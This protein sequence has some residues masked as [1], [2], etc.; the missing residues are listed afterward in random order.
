[1]KPI[2]WILLVAFVGLIFGPLA[3]AAIDGPYCC[4]LDPL[5]T[6]WTRYC[7]IK[8]FDPSLGTL[9]GV[10]IEL[11]A[12]GSQDISLDSE[13]SAE[14]TFTVGSTGS[15]TT[16]LPDGSK[17]ILAATP[18]DHI[19]TLPP[20]S[21]GYPPDF[22][23]DDADSWTVN[24]CDSDQVIVD[25]SK[26]AFYTGIGTASYATFATGTASLKAGGNG[27]LLWNTVIGTEICVTYE[28]EQLLCI[29][30]TKINDCTGAG[31]PGWTINLKD[32]S[33]NVI[34]TAVTDP[35]GEYSFCGLLPGSY[36]VCEVM[37]AGWK[38]VGDTC[39]PVTLED[40]DV[41]GV[42]FTNTPLFCISGHKFKSVTGVG[43]AGWTINL[44]DATGALIKTTTTGADG[45]Y[46]FCDIAPGSY[47]V[48]EVMKAGWKSVTP[49]CI[50]VNLDCEDSTDN[51]FINEPVPVSCGN[52]CPWYIKNELYIAKCGVLKEVPASIGILANDPKG[53]KVIRPESIT[54]DPKY[55]TLSVEEDG[56]FEYYPAPGIPNGVYVLFRYGATNGACDATGQGYAKIQVR[57]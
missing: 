1:M 14:Y 53:S 23:G 33:G 6:D 43:L 8:K 36:T 28:Y 45:S 7:D 32:A 4:E 42:D 35:N 5:K 11:E 47:T 9:T 48:C 39:I 15:A 51:D 25:P 16:T 41:D 40:A 44:K 20:D 49:T 19:V 12:C 31:L 22:I 54:I 34:K 38:N 50:A 56:S 37:K 10:T 24:A 13:D 27:G 30:G 21:D 18:D 3:S 29:N 57:C 17:V 26:F 2:K 46:R 55:G 52:R